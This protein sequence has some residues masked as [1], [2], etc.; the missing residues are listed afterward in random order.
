MNTDRIVPLTTGDERIVPLTAGSY[1]DRLYGRFNR[2][3]DGFKGVD[4]DD[5]IIYLNED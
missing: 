2:V 4:P 5:P 3:Y 1:L